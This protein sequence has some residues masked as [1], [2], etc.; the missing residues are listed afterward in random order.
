VASTPTILKGSKAP[1]VVVQLMPATMAVKDLPVAVV[2]Q[3]MAQLVWVRHKPVAP[4][5]AVAAMQ[6]AAAEPDMELL[7]MVEI[8]S[9]MAIMARMA[10]RIFQETE[11]ITTP[12]AVA[13]AAEPTALLN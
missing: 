10:V 6:A 12:E 5:V 2:A 7:D 13:V 4:E 8:A 11:E 9:A 3:P 1:E